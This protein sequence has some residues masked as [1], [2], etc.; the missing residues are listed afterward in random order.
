MPSNTT[1]VIAAI[2]EAY[3]AADSAARAAIAA[4]IMAS[5]LN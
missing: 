2:T 3:H 5:G 1:N 4:F